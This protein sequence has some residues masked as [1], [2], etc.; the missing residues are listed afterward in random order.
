MLYLL[1][2]KCVY[3]KRCF[4]AALNNI[5]SH[6]RSSEQVI[7]LSLVESYRLPV[8]TYMLLVH[9]LLHNVGCT[10]LVFVRTLRIVLF[11]ALVVAWE[12]VKSFIHGLGID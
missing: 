11:L 4:Y 6:A 2:T 10:I 5:M 8:L 7:Q 3:T 12:S 9:C 1:Y